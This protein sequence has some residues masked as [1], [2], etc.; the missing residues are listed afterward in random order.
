M[1]IIILKN[2]GMVRVI[3]YRENFVIFWVWD[4]GKVSGRYLDVF[5]VRV[6]GFYCFFV[7]KNVKF[8]VVIYFVCYRMFY[9]D[10]IG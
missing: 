5:I 4:V 9:E 10:E 1:V 2:L 7:M 8:S 6:F 3:V